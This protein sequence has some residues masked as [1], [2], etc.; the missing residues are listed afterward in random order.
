LSGF[1]GTDYAAIY[2]A[3]L[4]TGKKNLA[5]TKELLEQGKAKG[6]APAWVSAVTAS[7]KDAEKYID[8]QRRALF[9]ALGPE[10]SKIFAA[11]EAA[12]DDALKSQSLAAQAAARQAA[13]QKAIAEQIAAQNRAVAEEQQ[14]AKQRIIQEQNRRERERVEA[15]RQKAEKREKENREYEASQERFRQSAAASQVESEKKLRALIQ[16]QQA[17]RMPQG[18][19]SGQPEGWGVYDY[20][21][22]KGQLIDAHGNP[23]PF[24][25]ASG[26][27]YYDAQG[28]P[29]NFRREPVVSDASGKPL[30]QRGEK[31]FDL[32]TDKEMMI[33]DDGIAY[34]VNA[35]RAKFMPDYGKYDYFN[36][37]GQL[38]DAYGNPSPS[39]PVAGKV[40]YDAQGNPVDYKR[41]PV[42]GDAN[43]TAISIQGNRYYDVA[44]NQEVTINSQGVAVPMTAIFQKMVKSQTKTAAGFKMMP[45]SQSEFLNMI[46]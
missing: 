37:Q 29:V 46:G 27:V 6:Y 26:K 25:I 40:Y 3:N 31:Y 45:M 4:S 18:D 13:E 12:E 38:I 44:T 15:E 19:Q 39:A 10:Q 5:D 36:E 1:S 22:E 42:A 2:K 43:G 21:N 33:G 9:A 7:V 34:D 23:A 17:A 35:Y 24:P 14:A 30:V 8:D 11:Q 41:N 32:I 16:S 28:S 20:I